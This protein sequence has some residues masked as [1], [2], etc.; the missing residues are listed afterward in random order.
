MKRAQ[1]GWHSG[2]SD[3]RRSAQ[4]TLLLCGAAF[5]LWATIDPAA[6][7]SY[8]VQPRQGVVSVERTPQDYEPLGIRLGVFNLNPQM[9]VREAYN[10]NVFATQS[11]KIGDWITTVSPQV[12]LQ[13]DWARHSL[14]FL[15]SADIN[16]YASR[17]SENYDNFNLAVDG[18]VDILRDSS[19]YAGTAYRQLHEPR[20]SPNN[21]DGLTPQEYWVW[22]NNVGY[23][24]SFGR[25]NL[26]LDG[27]AD[28]YTYAELPTATGI[29][30]EVDRN[31]LDSIG[32]I[33]VGYDML[34]GWEPFVRTRFINSDYRTP[35]DRGGFQKD[36]SGYEVTGGTAF[37][38]NDLYIGEAFVGYVQR[39]FSDS[40][41]SNVEDPTFGLGLVAN[42][43]PLTAVKAVI[44]RTIGDTVVA[45]ASTSTDTFYGISADTEVRPNVVVG[46]E[47][48]LIHSDFNGISRID[49]VT[50]VGTRARYYLNRNFSFGPEIQYITRDAQNSGGPDDFQQWL[51]I[52]Q[53]TGKI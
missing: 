52:I 36:N 31:R 6:A 1:N 28:Q 49:D 37:N 39:D 21:Q 32:T 41:F 53:L 8:S 35:V 20:T 14:G 48:N 50:T 22:A 29:I 12:Q 17:T 15:A 10:D 40:R 19:V 34:T 44:N 5:A 4:A 27:E 45:G 7:D 42:I 46:A 23:F 3:V 47:A 26:R 18:R 16:K 51:F 2:F 43:T 9:T 24:Q 33:R 25:L 13:S 11:N 30:N 38:F